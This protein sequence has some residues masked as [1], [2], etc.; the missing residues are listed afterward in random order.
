MLS[1]KLQKAIDALDDKAVREI[2]D[3]RADPNGEPADDAPPLL[4]AT[5]WG[6]AGFPMVEM[7]LE[8]KADP[9][10][11]HLTVSRCVILLLHFPSIAHTYS[12]FLVCHTA[13]P[14]LVQRPQ[15]RG[16]SALHFAARYGCLRTVKALVESKAPVNCFYHS[17]NFMVRP[18]GL[19]ACV[20]V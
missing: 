5:L 14:N 20:L 17:T 4:L 9:S 15:E 11:A 19:C 13:F 10:L 1:R 2:L 6:P 3:K 18:V 8:A 12:R 7:L 16:R